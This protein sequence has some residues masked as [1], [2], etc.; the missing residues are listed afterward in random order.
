MELPELKGL[1]QKLAPSQLQLG[2]DLN[3]GYDA[4]LYNEGPKAASKVPAVAA[5]YADDAP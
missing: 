2:Q 4:H 1:G 3:R 5:S